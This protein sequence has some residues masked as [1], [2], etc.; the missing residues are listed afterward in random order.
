MGTVRATV[1][2]ESADTGGI[3]VATSTRTLAAPRR[4]VIYNPTTLAAVAPVH[5]H[6]IGAGRFLMVFSRRWH[7]ATPTAGTPGSYANTYTEDEEPG[8]ALV[9]AHSVRTSGRSFGVPGPAQRFLT[10]ACSRSN[11]YLYLLST[12]GSGAALVQHFRYSPD[13][14]MMLP[15]ASETLADRV[16]PEDAGTVRFDRGI[17]LDGYYMVVVGAHLESGQIYLARKSWGRVGVNTPTAKSRATTVESGEDPSWEYFRGN[18]WS[19]DIAEAQTTG[20]STLGP[21]STG[22]F[23]NRRYLSTVVAGETEHDRAARVWV[24][25]DGYQGWTVLT[26]DVALGSVEDGTYLGGTLA[27]QQHVPSAQQGIPYLTAVRAVS[28][29]NE[30]INVSWD[31]WP[32]A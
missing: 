3:S 19:H 28:D 16:L 23:R 7:T 12:L 9:D 24:M 27:L 21:V 32:V 15:V 14:D 17:Y 29:S 5:F 20:M 26:P 6:P 18:G 10:A 13:R 22:L 11:V 25:R 8:W 2:E 31:V 1:P 30:R 4:G